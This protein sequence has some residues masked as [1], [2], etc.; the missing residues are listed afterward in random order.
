MPRIVDLGVT[1]YDWVPGILGLTTPSAPK[2]TELV[3]AGTKNISPYV[4][5]TTDIAPAPSDTVNEKGITDTANVVIPTVGNYGGNL[6]LFRDYASGVPSA[7]D[8]LTTIGSVSGI[9]GWIVRRV[10]L[11]YSTPYALGQRVDVF[12]FMTDNPLKTGGKDDG[13]LKVTIPLLPQG[14]FY[15]E[16]TTVA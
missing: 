3:I 12:L 9:V 15:V 10:G 5:T 14:I 1:R 2:V 7:N 11:P 8:P 4:V 16:A 13:Y 6:I